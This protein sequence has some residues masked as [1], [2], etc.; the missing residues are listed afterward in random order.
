LAAATT[1]P[2]LGRF[3]TRDPVGDGSNWYAYC[4]NS[5]VIR[6]DPTG[7]W[8]L[9]RFLV[10]GDANA[11]D[12]MYDGGL[13]QLDHSW[14]RWQSHFADENRVFGPIAAGLLGLDAPVYPGVPKPRAYRIPG[15]SPY[16]TPIRYIDVWLRRRLGI[17]VPGL[18]A[19]ADGTKRLFVRYPAVYA[20]ARYAPLALLYGEVFLAIRAGRRTMQDPLLEPTLNSL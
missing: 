13:R 14:N 16:T 11:P 18:K 7:L 15:A 4:E 3:L 9:D 6:A 5:P 2:S 1:T 19:L 20:V 12:E 8:T 10:T 17:A